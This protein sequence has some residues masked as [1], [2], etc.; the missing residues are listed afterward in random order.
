MI[1]FFEIEEDYQIY[2]KGID[3]KIPDLSSTDH[4][5]L[6]VGIV[7][8]KNGHNYFVPLSSFKAQQRT[9][10]V[11]SFEGR[12]LSS[13]RF[14]FMFPV[15]DGQLKKK[16]IREE[17]NLGFRRLLNKEYSVCI[18]NEEEILAMAD[19]VYDRVVN[20]NDPKY[21]MNCCKFLNLEEAAL[22]YGN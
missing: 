7:L 6:G 10:Y 13:L 17:P 4:P 8:I 21:V 14:C 22:N 1:D 19:K 12:K 15:P 5:K 2:L 3:N 20:Y 11:I 16:I 9:N 18:A